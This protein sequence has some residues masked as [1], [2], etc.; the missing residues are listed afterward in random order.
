MSRK[1]RPRSIFAAL[2]RLPVRGLGGRL[3]ADLDEQFRELPVGRPV[4]ESDR[5]LVGGA[6][7]R[8]IALGLEHRAHAHIR[9]DA[10][11]LDRP[12]VGLDRS[13]GIAHLVVQEVPV[14]QECDRVVAPSALAEDGEGLS[15]AAHQPEQAPEIEERCERPGIGRAPE[16]L[17]GGLELAAIGQ[18]DRALVELLEGRVI[19]VA[20]L[21]SH[22]SSTLPAGAARPRQSHSARGRAVELVEAEWPRHARHAARCRCRSTA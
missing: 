6:R 5:G 13:R 7:P 20:R 1:A 18:L 3:L 12:A 15:R 2:D 8:D 19:W 11:Q 14:L 17:L 22:L 21:H 16:G 4:T 9:V 10:A